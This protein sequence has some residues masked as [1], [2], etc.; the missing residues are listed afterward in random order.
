MSGPGA[1]LGSGETHVRHLPL[2]AP[3]LVRSRRQK[4]TGRSL[5]PEDFTEEVLFEDGIGTACLQLRL[6]KSAF[7]GTE[8]DH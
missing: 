7:S 5:S 3:S 2:G 8:A 1:E 4:I 6:N